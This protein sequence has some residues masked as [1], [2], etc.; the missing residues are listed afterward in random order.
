M[1]RFC[2]RF[3]AFVISA[4]LSFPFHAQATDLLDLKVGLKVLPLLNEKIKSP[5]VV[6]IVYDPS[7]PESKAEAESI[8]SLIDGGVMAPGGI[9]L[10]SMLVGVGEMKKLSDA[11]LAFLSGSLSESDLDA[12]GKAAAMSN[13]LTFS[14]HLAYV[15]ENKCVLGIVSK[16]SVQIFY[17][18]IAADAGKIS[19]AQAFI[20]LASQL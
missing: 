10:T 9:K 1:N 19:F 20:M 17:S 7:K 15:K 8:K 5:A 2:L 13:V 12:A 4:C 3:C 14:T 11:K 16:P 6:G 18:P